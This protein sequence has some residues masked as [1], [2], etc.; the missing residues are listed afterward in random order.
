MDNVDDVSLSYKELYWDEPEQQVKLMKIN[1]VTAENLPISR[2]LEIK[3]D[4]DLFWYDIQDLN[5]V[6]IEYE[7]IENLSRGF[8]FTWENILKKFG[9]PRTYLNL[10]NS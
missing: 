1:L 6:Q 5:D 4:L 10:L 2:L 8:K 3:N 7:V 9:L